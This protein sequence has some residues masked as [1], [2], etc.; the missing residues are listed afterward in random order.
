M[1]KIMQTALQPEIKEAVPDSTVRVLTD[2]FE[3]PLDEICALSS[4]L[5]MARKVPDGDRCGWDLEWLDDIVL[6]RIHKLA[7]KCRENIGNIQD[8]DPPIAEKFGF[9]D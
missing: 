7:N 1:R 4:L 6:R 5:R 8:E 9:A 2:Y 3:R